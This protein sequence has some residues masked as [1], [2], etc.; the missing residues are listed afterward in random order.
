MQ[1]GS[2]R[3]SV[4]SYTEKI[5]NRRMELDPDSIPPFSCVEYKEPKLP[6]FVSLDSEWNSRNS[7]GSSR[8]KSPNYQT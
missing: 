7:K 2:F 8:L 3:I 6:L 1:Q 5:H 4:I